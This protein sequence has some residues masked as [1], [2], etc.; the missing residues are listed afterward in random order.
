MTIVIKVSGTLISHL[1]KKWEHNSQEEVPRC[2]FLSL[3]EIGNARK[4][5]PGSVSR[6]SGRVN[7]PQQGLGL[8]HNQTMLET[9]H[10]GLGCCSRCHLQRPRKQ[11]FSPTTPCL[12]Q[13]GLKVS[14]GFINQCIQVFTGSKEVRAKSKFRYN[15]S[16]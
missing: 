3:P 10:Q 12:T 1:T 15:M 5:F 6:D 2:G 4:A 13:L 16:I 11:N 14:G 7:F 9:Y 8:P